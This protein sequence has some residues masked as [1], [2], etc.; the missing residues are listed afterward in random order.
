MSEKKP[1]SLMIIIF[2][3]AMFCSYHIYYY[4]I[5]KAND[6]LIKN[7]NVKEEEKDTSQGIV[8]KVSNENNSKDKYFAIL[9][10]PKINLVEGFYNTDNDKNNVNKHV[11]M[12]KESTMPSKNGSIIYLAAH[13]G[14]GYIAYFKNL[15]KL[16]IGDIVNI[17]YQDKNYSYIINDI[18]EMSK[19]GTITVNHNIHENYLVLT[20]CSKNKNQQLVI[21]SKLI[22]KI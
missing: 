12:L 5:N 9:E 16:S 21:T 10:I 6:S 20:T 19:N 1:L 4:V 22:N 2:T 18:Y 17:K 14:N 7:Y 11:A 3:I 8:K 15:D 13:S